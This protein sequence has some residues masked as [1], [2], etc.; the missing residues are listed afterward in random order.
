VSNPSQYSDEILVQRF[1]DFLLEIGIP[2]EYGDTTEQTFLPGIEVVSGGLLIDRSELLYPGDIL[3][4]AG[5]LAVAPT[6]IRSSLTGEVIIPGEQPGTV[7]AAAM[8][9]SYAACL[10]LD[11]DPRVVFH[12]HGYHGRSLGLLQNFALGVFPG[13]HTL[14][15]F[16]MTVTS[17][18]PSAAFPV[19]GRWLRA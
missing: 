5:H 6:E 9:W 4:E 18:D 3:H 15:T 16:G 17:G 2:V 8:C 10:H 11:I 12:E 13:L 19:M 7:E 1:V 14:E